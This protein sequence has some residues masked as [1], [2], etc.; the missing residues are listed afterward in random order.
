[1]ALQK[2]IVASCLLLS[3]GVSSLPAAETR[4]LT[5][6]SAVEQALANNLNLSLQRQEVTIAAG[7][8][9][10]ATGKFDTTLTAEG[11]YTTQES[12]PLMPGYA[13]EED[14]G[15][16][17]VAASKLFTTGT[18]ITLGWS[19]NR[20]DSNTAGLLLDP[21]Y[22]SGLTFGLKQS[23]LRGFGK[24]IQTAEI[25]TAEKQ[26][27]AATFQVD[28]QAADLA[29]TVKK[30]YWNL[31][32]AYQNI[33]VQQLNLTLAKKL[34]EETEAKIK[35]G[36]MAPVELYQP[37]SEVARREE[38]LISAERAIGVAE[39]ELKLQLNS[40][41]WQTTFL[42]TDEP[43]TAPVNLQEDIILQHAL[44][45]RPD[46]KASDQLTEAARI[47]A[48]R[49]TD[50]TRPDLSLVGKV[51]ITGTE[52]TYG[53]S[54]D[55]SLGDPENLWQ[56]G[57]T[58]TMPLGNEVARGYQ[59]QAQAQYIKAKLN[60]E[61]LKQEVRRTVRTTI[62]DVTLAIKALEAT[63]KTSL[64]T[65]K[66]LEAEQAKFDSGLSTTLD[67]LAA[68]QAYSTALSQEK[69]TAIVYANSLAE[70]DRIQGLVTI[71]SDP[72]PE[73]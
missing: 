29:A 28:S 3:A 8:L 20:Y 51:G 31:V 13:T 67:V 24:D 60:G 69:Q 53:D 49:A 17:S 56:V 15:A 66:R 14:T 36:K 42:P 44:T 43:S 40:N 52:Q 22:S 4:Q 1:M 73:S 47:E 26:L 30:D 55:D 16:W 57:L 9:K 35:V 38:Q 46:I 32:Y 62:R 48:K 27:A 72:V 21:T 18:D 33:E 70:L 68:Q 12:K 54:I 58:L 11:G 71:S 50:A 63:R 25:Q 39:D 7:G 64:A 19:N 10:S 34:L 6:R 41:Q 65:Q 45:N 59:Q 2:I 61:L 23:L 37:L 5:L